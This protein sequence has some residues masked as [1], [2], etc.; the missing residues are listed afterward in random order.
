MAKAD[1]LPVFL[2]SI[3]IQGFKS[4]ADRVKLELGHGLSVVVGPNGSGKSNV[5]DAIRWVLGEQS[6]KNLR[7]SKMEDII[8]SGS[9]A[10]RPVGMA[11]VSLFFDNSTGIFP[12]EYQ[13]VIITRRV[14]R[15]GEGQ[16]FINRSPC[17]LKDIH[18]LFMDTGAG[19]EGFSIIGQGR[20]EELLNQRS[21]DR[22]TLIEEASGITK[23]RMR[24]REALK[25]LDETERN[26][27]RIRDILA[28][29]EGQL[30]PLEEQAAIAKEAVELTTEQKALEI[31]VV[32]FDLKEVRNKLASAVQETEELQLA[33]AAAVADLGQKESEILSNKVKLNLLDEHIQKQQETTY[34]LD[35][36]VNEIIQ[37][38]RLRQEREGYLG[39]QI[40]RVTTEL[41]TYDEKVRQSAE[42]LRALEDRKSLLHKTLDQANQ[43]LAEDE[44][45]LAEAKARNG[46]EEIETLR[47]NLSHLQSKLAESTTGLS[48]ITHQLDTLNSTH[49]Q[50]IKEKGDKETGLLSYEQQEDHV[51][52]Q[53]EA[54]E[55][56]QKDIRLKAE[57]T[58]QEITQ[59]REQSKTEQKE[60]QELHRE[61][62]KK[63]ARYHALKNLEDSL[64]GYQRGVRELML[65]KKKNIPACGDLC[66]TL[67]DLLQVE[68]RYEVAIEVAL[69][70]GIQNIVTETERGAKEAVHYLKSR[71]L[72]R[73]T[74]LPLDV[75]QGGKTNVAKEAA[76]DPGFI[77]VAVDL[78]AFQEKY[79]KA[80]ESQLGRTLIVTD[81]EA[82]TRVARA[83]GYRAR[84]VTLEGE[85]VH[86][87]G[88]LTG[89]SLQRKGSNI[90]G[91][92]REIEELRKECEER[93]TRQRE[94]EV[95]A[96]TLSAQIRK[97][98]ES[99]KG[100][101]GEEQELKSAMAVLRTQEANL[102]EQMQR[103]RDEITALTIRMAGI[104]QERNDLQSHKTLGEG[105]QSKLAASIKEAQGALVLQEEK[106]QKAGQEMELLQ[107]RLTQ[108]KVQAAKWEQELKQAA[109][110]LEQDQ[111]LLAENR[112]LLERKRKDLKD[113]E[114]G[115]A[116]LAF[117]QEDWEGRRREAGEQLQQAQE[118]L[119][120]L[121]KER[122]VLSKE[123]MD[124]E[125]LAQ[126][127]RQEQQ[128]LEQKLHNLELKTARWDAEWETGSKR[129]LE[130]FALTWD[131][132]Q[133]Y[134]SER[135]R[136]ELAS[137]VQEIKLRMELLGPV[138]Q[139]A[140]EEYPKLQERYDFLSVQGQDLEE[141]NE[142]LH[143]L[144]AELDKTMS[145]R[146]EEGFIAV[147]EAFKVVFKELF[148][149]G[150]A[151]L[152]LVDPANLLDTGVEIIA[153]PPGKKPQLLSLLS[154]G[155]RALTAI[156]L[157]FALLKVK[158]SPFCILDE[159]EASLDDANVSRFAQYIHRLADSTQFLVISHRKGT[160]E[161][162][163]VLYGIT[164]EESGVSKLLSVQLEGQDK[165]TRTA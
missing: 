88:S 58:H 40:N 57:R 95:K 48:R 151:E 37:E 153:Q 112:H 50:L 51:R 90:L 139:A 87:G 47:G 114:E 79:R 20:V 30:G 52:E 107:E 13:E 45:C 92:S 125:G 155:E 162:A 78:I 98:E 133:S 23:Y 8:F 74:F 144:I 66:G 165:D 59:L 62:E 81:M 24:K 84:I 158:P 102:R 76:K 49:Q 34:Q 132:A 142:S 72:G 100:L 31:E 2:K 44:Q 17:R 131:E 99:L 148:N 138:N 6:A 70:A 127:K 77:G 113:L 160:M 64:E 108:T 118:V 46:L 116:R 110:R 54:Q 10:R 154:G 83:S 164:M 33:I 16:Y 32:A 145:E 104:E 124:Q 159:I 39:E 141:A 3:T 89:G 136:A 157:L 126:K 69:G 80:F 4:F 163:D 147:N 143:Q 121:R 152:R 128:A 73:A 130:E 91:R 109:E 97:G 75:I 122:E 111:A 65:A 105:E 11:E 38:L 56:I 15:D 156:G 22:R 14:Y 19:K 55:G 68:E 150:Y 9:S 29:I 85:Q 1:T 123:L 67:A 120:A 82:A 61:L 71:N 101:M 41:S 12:L 94:L 161:A 119:I 53:I 134:Q 43:K 21:E 36:A 135:N 26:L 35:Q 140:I 115:K 96:G 149:G 42:Q 27:E 129:L 18:E 60:L 106:N 5:A 146:F 103:I 86:P 63:S 117:E 137:R 28:E 25:R 93:G 7:G